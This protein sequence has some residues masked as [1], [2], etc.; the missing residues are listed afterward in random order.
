MVGDNQKEIEGPLHPDQLLALVTEVYRGKHTIRRGS[1]LW[2][3]Y[4]V[5]WLMIR[6]FRRQVLDLLIKMRRATKRKDYVP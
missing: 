6:P 5:I 4:S 2:F 1:P 3:F